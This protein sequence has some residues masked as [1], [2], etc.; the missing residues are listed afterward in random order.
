MNP[1]P[2]TPNPKRSNPQPLTQNPRPFVVKVGG[3]VL[4][5]EGAVA[6]L[7]RG[8]RGLRAARPVVVVHGG[9]AQATALAARLG[10]TPT[11]VQGRR[12]TTDLDLDIAQWALRGKLNTQLVARAQRHGLRAVGVSGADGGLVRV[13]RRPPWTLGG[14]EVD[15]GWVGDVEGVAPGALACLLA[16]GFVPVVAPLGIDGDGH[17]YNV[18]ADTVA[19]ALAVALGAAAL[20]FVTPTGGVRRDADDPA[21]HLATLDRDAFAAGVAGGW[22][23]GGMRVKLTT[24]FEALGGG[25]A[26]AYVGAPGDLLALAQA[27]RVIA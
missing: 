9:G 11:V 3:G 13:T 8:V 5:D 20:A 19:C 1:Q 14:A 27:T 6:A 24:A 18:N 23:R 7:W 15:F 4:A 22:I 2:P 21:S 25:V 10:H 17:V 16:G 12:V 26:A